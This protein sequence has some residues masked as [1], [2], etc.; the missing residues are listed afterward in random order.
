ML[1]R[2]EMLMKDIILYHGSRGGLEGN[3]TPISR[4][5]TDFGR[6]FYLGTN[7][8]QAKGLVANEKNAVIYTMKLKLSEIP[9]D[10]ILV[11]SGQDW[12]YTVLAN[13]QRWEKFNELAISQTY[14][15]LVKNYDVIIGPI[16]DD[17]MNS[18][19]ESFIANALTDT[20]LKACLKAVDY[21]Q[22]YVLKTPF[23]CGK[24]EIINSYEMSE[25]EKDDAYAYCRHLQ[26][27]GDVVV[28]NAIEEYQRQGLYF[29]EI[30]KKERELEKSSLNN[31][32]GDDDY[33]R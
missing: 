5:K 18:S 26:A 12:L 22:Q 11:L 17:R 14:I 4:V 24:I 6:G 28:N 30:I 9:E 27:E 15:D 13:R 16:A 7:K 29:N 3:I 20:G 19:V 25:K 10:R 1:L 2:E 21:G 31:D 33:E 8:N 32:L 23:A